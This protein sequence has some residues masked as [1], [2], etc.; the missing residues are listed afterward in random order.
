MAAAENRSASH[1]GS[2]PSGSQEVIE[3]PLDEGVAVIVLPQKISQAEA[4][5]VIGALLERG[6]DSRR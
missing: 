3:V 1:W 2:Q 5:R 4:T 6:V